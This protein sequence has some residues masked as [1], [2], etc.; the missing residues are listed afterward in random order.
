L[1]PDVTQVFVPIAKSDAA[2]RRELDAKI[3]GQF[4]VQAMQ[5]VYLPGLVGAAKVSF[6]EAK[7]DIDYRIE[8]VL[9]APVAESAL[10]VDW[11]PS[12]ELNL[13]MRDLSTSSGAAGE[14]QGPFYGPVPTT[15]N[16]A[17]KVKTASSKFA[18]YV[19]YESRLP[20]LVHKGLAIYQHPD[21]PEREF[22]IRLQQAAREA[23]DEEVDA[24]HKRY[25]GQIEKVT[26]RLSQEERDFDIKKQEHNARIQQE[27]IGIGE[28]VLNFFL[29]RRSSSI[30]S[31]AASKRRLS[32][33]AKA[34]LEEQEQ[35]IAD[36]TQDKE[37]LEAELS[38]Q[39]E[40][41][42]ARWE[43]VL[44]EITTEELTPR[45][46][47]VDV[48]LV[49]LAWL[50]HWRIEYDEGFGA[51]SSLVEAYVPEAGEAGNREAR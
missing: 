28:S 15:I 36:L 2:A 20:V 39:A 51:R 3:G 11:A 23:R 27:A 5:L 10:D 43:G 8:R 4:T 38:A 34:A 29:G 26:R 18:D 12:Q 35:E 14:G 7:R 1:A 50:P 21:E 30:F 31:S 47:D 25:Q 46:S 17:R 45:R 33:R 37:E 41:I 44:D 22:R 13:S 6:V 48:A 9:A 19:Y 24:L 32:A 49:A 40:E 42:T 16:T